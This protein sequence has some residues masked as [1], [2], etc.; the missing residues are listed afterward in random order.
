MDKGVKFDPVTAN[1]PSEWLA[2]GRGQIDAS[3]PWWRVDSVSVVRRLI[4]II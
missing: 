1:V 2:Y 4:F 3:V